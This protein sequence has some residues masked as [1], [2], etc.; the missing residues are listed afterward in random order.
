MLV[1]SD[2]RPFQES[3]STSAG[4]NDARDS[5]KWFL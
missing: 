3:N 5:T 1:L 2:I 4:E